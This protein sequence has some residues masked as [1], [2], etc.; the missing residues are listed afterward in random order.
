MQKNQLNKLFKSIILLI[1]IIIGII[2]LD[3]HTTIELKKHL[4]VVNLLRQL[5]QVTTQALCKV[6]YNSF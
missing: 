1:Q 5:L 3:I 4:V 2:K 6:K